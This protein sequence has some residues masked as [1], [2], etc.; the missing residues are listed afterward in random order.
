MA[1]V[2]FTC[3][4]YCTCLWSHISN[5]LT[6]LVIIINTV[7]SVYWKLQSKF[8]FASQFTQRTL[9][10]TL[11]P[12]SFLLVMLYEVIAEASFQTIDCACSISLIMKSYF[13]LW[14]EQVW[15]GSSQSHSTQKMS[16]HNSCSQFSDNNCSHYTTLRIC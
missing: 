8:C 2:Y 5:L 12:K 3:Y 16:E 10:E 4:I 9:I 1:P 13:G 15:R 6:N 7:D 11:S 14:I